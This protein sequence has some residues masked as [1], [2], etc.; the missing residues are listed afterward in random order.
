MFF[1]ETM[2]NHGNKK[3]QSILIL[4]FWGIDKF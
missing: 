1:V 2:E 4:F 3:E